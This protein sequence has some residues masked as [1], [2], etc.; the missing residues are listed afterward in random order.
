MKKK[1]LKIFIKAFIGLFIVYA[2][3]LVS[4]IIYANY[5][6]N[7]ML[8]AMDKGDSDLLNELI[9]N[10]N[11][12]SLK[13]YIPKN[14]EKEILQNFSY[15]KAKTGY[16]WGTAYWKY[17]ICTADPQA[18]FESGTYVNELVNNF[19][20]I[21]IKERQ[22]QKEIAKK[23]GTYGELPES[24]GGSFVRFMSPDTFDEKTYYTLLERVIH[25]D[26]KLY[27]GNSTKITQIQIEYNIFTHQFKNL[28]EFLELKNGEHFVNSAD[29][30]FKEKNLENR[31]RYLTMYK[32]G[33]NPLN[34]ITLDERFVS[35]YEDFE[36]SY[37]E[38][39]ME[40]YIIE[41]DLSSE[42]AEKY[43]INQG[44][45]YGR[46]IYLENDEDYTLEVVFDNDKLLW[47]SDEKESDF[48]KEKMDYFIQNNVGKME[49]LKELEN[50]GYYKNEELLY[51]DPQIPDVIYILDGEKLE[52][53][54]T[55]LEEQ[56]YIRVEEI[57]FYKPNF[58]Y[59]MAYFYNDKFISLFCGNN[60]HLN[61]KVE[62]FLNDN[63]TKDE[64]INELVNE[65]FIVEN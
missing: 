17:D 50:L 23:T 46:S 64:I 37:I 57:Y 42:D 20:E 61:E 5:T 49:I 45:M 65:G 39:K 27:N 44:Y 1:F 4:N 9:D 43:L 12:Y 38:N 13:S 3:Y 59:I 11:I 47:I 58:G 62:Y 25:Q 18:V 56:G 33:E 29:E 32:T 6:I 55:D 16:F 40:K 53:R 34:I 10:Y 60:A 8:E 22:L 2:I 14:S 7:L 26:E 48:I 30:I 52:E 19:D 63:L 51:A 15:K 28:E 41:N 35:L 21:Y 36:D 54:F 31:L 24:Y